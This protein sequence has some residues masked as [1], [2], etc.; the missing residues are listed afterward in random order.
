MG[1]VER[2]IQYVDNETIE[3]AQKTFARYDSVGQNG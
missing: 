2:L 3:L 1:R